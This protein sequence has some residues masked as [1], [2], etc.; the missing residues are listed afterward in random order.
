MISSPTLTV[1]SHLPKQGEHE[2]GAKERLVRFL[3]LIEQI[4]QRSPD[5]AQQETKTVSPKRGEL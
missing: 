5:Q 4:N 3:K 2:P 1:Q